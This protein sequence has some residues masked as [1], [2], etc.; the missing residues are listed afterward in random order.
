LLALRLT[1]RVRHEFGRELP[2]ASVVSSPTVAQLAT[3]LR[4]P[5][6]GS[7]A[8]R[9]VPLRPTG[10][11]PPVFLVHA[12]GGQVFR[13]LPLARRLGPDQPVYAIA[14]AGLAPGEA[15]HDTLAEM[16]DDYVHHIRAVR[17]HGPYVLGGFCIGG[18]IALEIARRL[19]EQGE[20]VPLV[21]L[22]YSDA[23]EPVVAS[24]LE[25]DTALMVHALAGAPLDTD[26]DELARLDPD[27]RLL[28]VMDAAAQEDRLPPDTADLEQA[29]RFLRVFRANAHAV[30][31]HRHEPYDG[32]VGLW[33]PA[34]DGA[35]ADDLGW[36]SVVAGRLAVARI[37]G[38]RFHI[39]YEP[40]VAEAAAKLRD[41]MDRGVADGD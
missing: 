2:V 34:T 9:I 16:V 1:M 32:D 15:P 8:A 10:D 31:H 27:E 28:A 39:M 25:D 21:V 14:A 24:T 4:Q 35:G 41:W 6:D 12:L 3:L 20:P 7:P 13:Y 30:G 36:R 11:R 40:L 26:L 29:R 19:R 22:F 5:D 17:P 23:D 38:E 33:A 37:P 18:N